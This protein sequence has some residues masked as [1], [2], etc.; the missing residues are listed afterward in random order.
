MLRIAMLSKWHVHAQEYAGYFQK[1]N[2]AKITCVWDE[3]AERWFGRTYAD[4][5]EVDG[6][7]YFESEDECI[8]GSFVEVRMDDSLGADLAGVRVGG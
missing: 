6:K 2:D 1:M 7:V 3:D 4:S 5:V 8:I